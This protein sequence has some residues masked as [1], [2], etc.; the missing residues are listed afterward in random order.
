MAFSAVSNHVRPR[1]HHLAGRLSIDSHPSLTQRAEHHIGRAHEIC[2]EQPRA[3]GYQ[4]AAIEWLNLGK[5][6]LQLLLLQGADVP[7]G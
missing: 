7:L 6:R 3:S 2:R 4:P 5:A 1:R